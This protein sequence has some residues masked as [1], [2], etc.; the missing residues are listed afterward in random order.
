MRVAGR[1]GENASP[2][3]LRGATRRSGR[4]RIT[5][6]PVSEGL[7]GVPRSTSF[8]LLPAR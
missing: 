7:R 2:L 8:R 4:Y 3:R 1:A 5:A 6:S